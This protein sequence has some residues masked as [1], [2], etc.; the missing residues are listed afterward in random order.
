MKKLCSK[1][2]KKQSDLM[3][4]IQQLANTKLEKDERGN[5]YTEGKCHLSSPAGFED[6]DQAAWIDCPCR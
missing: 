1:Y 2:E 4:K 5:E 3:S 6:I